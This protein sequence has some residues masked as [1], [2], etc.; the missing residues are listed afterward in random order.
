MRRA[1]K[2]HRNA[3][4]TK[5]VPVDRIY[6]G[7]I[8]GLEGSRPTGSEVQRFVRALDATGGP[9]NPPVVR[10]AGGG[11]FDLVTG[12]LRYAAELQRGKKAIICSIRQMTDAEAVMIAFFEQE[13]RRKRPILIRAWAAESAYEVFD[14]SQADLADAIGR[15][16]TEVSEWLAIARAVPE[17]ML[18]A[19]A[20]NTGVESIA[21]VA[22]VKRATCRALLKD[23]DPDA[24][25]LALEH[26]ISRDK[27]SAPKP[28]LALVLKSPDVEM[29]WVEARPRLALW[30]TAR[31]WGMVLGRC[32]ASL[33]ASLLRRSSRGEPSRC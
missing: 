11:F 16:E 7:R 2:T 19:A 22:R 29:R 30:V 10:P 5:E 25:R 9:V 12:E 3:V 31:I 24:R 14:G 21:A 13:S 6:V 32:L 23:A 20:H 1:D 15:L 26:H 28:T 18:D 8:P 4:E 27:R 33:A 17:T